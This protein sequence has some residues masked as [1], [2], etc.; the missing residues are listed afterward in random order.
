MLGI[1]FSAFAKDVTKTVK[2][3]GSVTQLKVSHCFNVTLSKTSNN[4]AVITIDKEY[5]PYLI[6]KVS[7]NTLVIGLDS[8]KMP[9]GMR[10]HMEDRTFNANISLKSLTKLSMSGATRIFIEDEYS[11][12]E[13]EGECSGASS[14]KNLRIE[15]KKASFDLSGA[16]SCS[17]SGKLEKSEIDCSGASKLSFEGKVDVCD[18]DVSG[19]SS[20]DMTTESKKIT[21]D[22]SGA[23]KIRLHGSSE[24]AS[25]ECSGA[26]SINADDFIADSADVDCSGASRTTIGVKSILKVELSGSSSL[27][28]YEKGNSAITVVPVSIG[29]GC[30]LKNR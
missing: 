14:V 7:G 23:S 18:I 29:R 2:V 9:R 5:E 11:V 20:V 8:D 28:Y 26:S 13:F 15:A 21:G 1:V 19:A 6:A 22:C 27:Y 17:V 4:A 3:G 10:N 16:S 24:I 12:N 30:T 25:L